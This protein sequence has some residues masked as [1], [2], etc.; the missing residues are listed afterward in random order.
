M[1]IIVVG[2]KCVLLLVDAGIS[3]STIKIRSKRRA[4]GIEIRILITH[5]MATGRKRDLDTGEYI[6]EHFIQQLTIEL[7]EKI[8]VFGTMAAGISKNPF[9]S[10]ML[11]DAVAGAIL[12]VHWV[13]NLGNEETAERII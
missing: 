6:P 8:I 9:F 4:N 5:P 11:S 7:N 10:F 2:N 12:S 3:V 1:I 13:D